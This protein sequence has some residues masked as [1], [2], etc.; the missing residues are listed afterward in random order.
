MCYLRREMT[1]SEDD[2]G[3]ARTFKEAFYADIIS[4][5]GTAADNAVLQIATALDV[6]FKMLKC[7][8]K[9]KREN[10]WQLIKNLMND[11]SEHTDSDVPEVKKPRLMNN[12]MFTVIDSDDD[13]DND[14]DEVE[15]AAN[16]RSSYELTLYRS[17]PAETDVDKDPLIFWKANENTYPIL[18]QLARQYLGVPAT[19]VT[20]ERLFSTA[21][22]LI[23]VKRNALEPQNANMLNS[24][25]C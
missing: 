18:S 19:S 3:Y 7:M 25:H 1:S 4:R 23:T 13:D 15:D 9:D 24:L 2:P 16:L 11:I 5:I 22:N 14:A 21:G 10:V 20:V 8:P 12:S 17:I 6:R